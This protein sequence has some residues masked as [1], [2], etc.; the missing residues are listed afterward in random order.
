MIRCIHLALLMTATAALIPGSTRAQSTDGTATTSWPPVADPGMKTKEFP[1]RKVEYFRHASRP[2]WGY[3]K[4]QQDYF[5]LVHP[6]TPRPDSPLYVVLHSA[7]HDARS[8]F[9]IGTEGAEGP[10]G[11]FLYYPPADCYGLYPDCRANGGVGD[12]WWGGPQPNEKQPKNLGLQPTPAERRVEDTVRWVL[13]QYPTNPD[14]VYLTGI[15]MGGSGS[16]G[17]GMPRG[18]LFASIMVHVPAGALHVEQRMPF[19]PLEAAAGSKRPDPPVVVAYS[20]VNDGWARDQAILLKGMRAGRYALIDFWGHSGHDS[21]RQSIASKCDLAFSFPWLEIRKNEAYPAFTSATSDS[22]A[23]W[24]TADGVP[25]DP[26]GQINAF[27]RWKNVL[28]TPKSFAIELRLLN[29]EEIT[30]TLPVPTE[31][32]ADVTLRRLQ[33]FHA[34]GGQEIEWEFR[35]QHEVLA[36]GAVKAD[37][38]GLLTIPQLKITRLPT[39]LHLKSR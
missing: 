30:T 4:P 22:R 10:R 1:G 19:P 21:T 16:L 12:W 18:D 5:I 39:V 28:D 34:A 6:E 35:R 33:N 13:S 25:A 24:L 38:A 26:S 14:R 32:T 3:A 23:P 2:E 37:E 11:H 8:A 9:E 31:S 29:P 20:G 7:G 15:S 27:F 17:I 36:K